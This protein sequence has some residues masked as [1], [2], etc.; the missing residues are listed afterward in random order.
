MEITDAAHGCDVLMSSFVSVQSISEDVCD[1]E[2]AQFDG[3]F[4]VGFIFLFSESSEDK[5]AGEPKRMC[6]MI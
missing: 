5:T 6:V 1:T 4:A 2:D 3:E